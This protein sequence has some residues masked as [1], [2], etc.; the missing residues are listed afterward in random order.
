MTLVYSHIL[1]AVDGSKEA[2]WAFKKAAGIAKRNQA[3]LNIAYIVDNRSFGAIE[4]YDKTSAQKANVYGNELVAGYKKEAME[5]GVPEVNGIVEYGVPKTLIPGE[6]AEKHQV[7]LIICGAS[8]LNATERF[9]MGSVS[10]R[11]V[12]TANCDVLV[13]RTP[14]T[15][16]A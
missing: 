9:L 14:E 7:D 1:V 13:V 5:S 11:I 10:E 6:L 12:R 16:E 4:A 8:G 15:D 3:V 2:E